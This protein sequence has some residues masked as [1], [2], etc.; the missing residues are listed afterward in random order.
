MTIREA[1]ASIEGVSDAARRKQIAE[2]L[3]R[4]GAI[5]R[6][7]KLGSIIGWGDMEPKDIERLRS[8]LEIIAWLAKNH[9]DSLPAEFAREPSE[10]EIKRALNKLTNSISAASRE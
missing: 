5:A 9:L 8:A 10:E 2:L 7:M 1:A 3:H 4:F 6:K